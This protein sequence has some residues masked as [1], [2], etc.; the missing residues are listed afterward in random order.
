MGMA[1]GPFGACTPPALGGAEASAGL[2]GRVFTE[3]APVSLFVSSLI[4]RSFEKRSLMQSHNRPGLVKISFSISRRSCG[5]TN[6]LMV[7]WTGFVI[8]TSIKIRI[9]SVASSFGGSRV[10]GTSVV[11]T[12][13]A[14]LP[15]SK[16]RSEERRVGK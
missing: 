10:D 4:F 13:L 2:A 11:D 16:V 7:Q 12:I 15:V 14:T 5:S 1:P 6:A 8:S 3:E 9:G